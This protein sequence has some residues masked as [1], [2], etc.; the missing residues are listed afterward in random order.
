MSE[1]KARPSRIKPETIEREAKVL[2]LRRGGLTF[3]LIAKE[4]GFANPS[5]AH[6]AYANACKR[7]I[8]SDVEELRGTELDRLDIAQGALWNKV[9]RG[10]V[11]AVMAVLKIMERRARLLGLDMPAKAQV[12]ITHYDGNT[13]D[14]EVER[15]VAL[16]DSGKTR[17]LDAPTSEN[18]T[19]SN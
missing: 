19:D 3:D 2:Q 18:G 7:I 5:G 6:K 16:L 17:S 12:E 8:R 10:E 11:P 1:G 15:L 14:S 4:L 9:M 13:I